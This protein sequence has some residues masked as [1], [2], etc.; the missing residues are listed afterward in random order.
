M[1]KGTRLRGEDGLSKKLKA[2]AAK[3]SPKQAET[4]VRAG[5]LVI[6]GAAVQKAP[7]LTGALRRSIHTETATTSA[8]AVG[9]TGTNVEYGPFQEFGTS[10]MR[11]QPFLRPAYDEN[12]DEALAEIERVLKEMVTP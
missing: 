3:A 7:V 1:A 2:L 4:A 5:L 8:G 6:E 12:K 9:R 11:A 10:R